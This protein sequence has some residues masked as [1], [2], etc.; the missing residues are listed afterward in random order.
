[1]L[2][3]IRGPS[4]PLI[5]PR[6]T[7]TIPAFPS[8]KRPGN[9]DGIHL[10]LQ[11]ATFHLTFQ[12]QFQVTPTAAMAS[13][14]ATL[15]AF[16]QAQKYAVVGASTN[17]EKYGFKGESCA[18]DPVIIS[19]Q[20]CRPSCSPLCRLVL[21]TGHLACFTYALCK[22]SWVLASCMLTWQQFSSGT[23]PMACP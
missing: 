1:M 17:T 5:N 7:R 6:A 12:R 13:S 11:P 9:S 22:R 16:F 15:R 8:P 4:I 3:R 21:L 20:K 18:S 2:R 14:E 10:R 19:C 23:S